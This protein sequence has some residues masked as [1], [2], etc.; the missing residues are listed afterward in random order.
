MKDLKV[1]VLGDGGWG[2]ALA[3]VLESNGCKPIV[4]GPFEDYVSQV[5]ETRINKKFLPDIELPSNISFTS[6]IKLAVESSDIIIVVVPTVHL[7]TVL[8]SIKDLDLSGKV[9]VS[10]TKGIEND[11]LLLP[12]QIIEEYLTGVNVVVLSGPSHAEEVAKKI[13][14]CVVVSSGS[15]DLSLRVQKLFSNQYFRIYTVE[16]MIGVELGGALK[17][18]IAIA[19]GACDGLSFGTNAKAALLS[20]GM[21]EMA[22]LGESFGANRETLF[23]LAGMGDL[24]TTCVSPYGRNRLVGER[25]GKGEKLKDI[26]DSMEMVAEGVNTAR[27]VKELAV[28][29]KVEMPISNEVYEILFNDK[30]PLD[31]ISDLMTRDV[32][33]EVY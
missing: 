19:G 23:G 17:N 29:N 7:R 1:S 16:D 25:I 28:K 32:K 14:T 30:N 3:L 22:R 4:W 11:T 20:R 26:L 5:Q 2:T 15:K 6:D 12:S 9:F 33:D 8:D 18:V 10:C 13:P 27:S 24:I 31:A 21:Q